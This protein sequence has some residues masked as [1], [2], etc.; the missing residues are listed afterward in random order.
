MVL[1]IIHI[2]PF[3]IGSITTTNSSQPAVADHK[4]IWNLED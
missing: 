1:I 2:S 3:L 4:I